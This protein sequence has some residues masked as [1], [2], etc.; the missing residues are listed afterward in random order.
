MLCVAEGYTSA[1]RFG[2]YQSAARQNI[3][4]CHMCSCPMFG[5]VQV[6]WPFSGQDRLSACSNESVCPAGCAEVQ[7]SVQH[8]QSGS[9]FVLM[10]PGLLCS[11]AT[12]PSIP[13]AACSICC[14]CRTLLTCSVGTQGLHGTERHNLTTVVTCL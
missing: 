7:G 14:C 13:P 8:M 2:W 10:S 4:C 1:R 5:N 3:T 9:F 12:S 6:H 11:T